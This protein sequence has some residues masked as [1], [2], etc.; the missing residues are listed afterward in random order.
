MN[1]TGKLD[2]PVPLS[3]C[4]INNF[5]AAKKLTNSSKDLFVID[6]LNVDIADK[7]LSISNKLGNLLVVFYLYISLVFDNSSCS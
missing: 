6:G 2:L 3:L 7:F 4:K 5:D 1:N